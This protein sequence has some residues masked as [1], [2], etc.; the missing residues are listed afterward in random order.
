VDLKVIV[1]GDGEKDVNGGE[2][3]NRGKCFIVVEA[4]NLSK[5]LCNYTSLMLFNFTIRSSLESENPFRVHN[6]S[7]SWLVDYFIEFHLPEDI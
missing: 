2:F 1:G 7:V 6:L 3:N 4:L 5:A